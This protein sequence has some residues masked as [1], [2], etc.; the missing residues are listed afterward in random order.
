M[1]ALRRRQRTAAGTILKASRTRG[2]GNGRLLDSSEPGELPSLAPAS[3][4]EGSATTSTS[5]SPSLPARFASPDPLLCSS[6]CP[7]DCSLH[8]SMSTTKDATYHSKTAQTWPRI[9]GTEAAAAGAQAGG[10]GGVQRGPIDKG[11]R[12]GQPQP[13]PV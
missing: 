12:G 1:F 6:V 9:A 5:A 8:R 4:L 10:Y 11:C 7:V 3:L 2:G 13:P